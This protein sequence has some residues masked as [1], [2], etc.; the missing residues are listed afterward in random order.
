MAAWRWPAALVPTT[1]DP[2]ELDAVVA[3]LERSPLINIA[4]WS[5][6]TTA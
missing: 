1:A 3:A 4:T 5:V 6:G 2:L